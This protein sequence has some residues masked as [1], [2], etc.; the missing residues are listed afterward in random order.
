MF[1]RW[2]TLCTLRISHVRNKGNRA[3][4]VVIRITIAVVCNNSSVLRENQRSTQF[5]HTRR[6]VAAI[7]ATTTVTTTTSS[8]AFASSTARA[9]LRH[10]EGMGS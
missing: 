3:T 1:I 10:W 4:A 7:T 9:R 8:T 5:H 6:T 2:F